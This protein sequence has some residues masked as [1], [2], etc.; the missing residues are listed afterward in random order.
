LCQDICF[1][2]GCVGLVVCVSGKAVW[3]LNPVPGRWL[4]LVAA[5]RRVCR[6]SACSAS[7]A[8]RVC[9]S[10]QQA[11]GGSN[12]LPGHGEQPPAKACVW[13]EEDGAS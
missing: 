11:L 5:E 9:P 4:L 1:E 10:M 13:F 6:G 7:A 2:K 3:G 12:S 8:G